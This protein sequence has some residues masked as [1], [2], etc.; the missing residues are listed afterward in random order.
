MGILYRDYMTDVVFCLSVD[1]REDV[2]DTGNH[3]K[4][5]VEMQSGAFYRE[6]EMP[7][8]VFID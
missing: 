3:R 6:P 5:V 1:I 2:V 4:F 8:R 7:G